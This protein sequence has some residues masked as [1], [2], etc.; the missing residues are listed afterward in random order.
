MAVQRNNEWEY[1]EETQHKYC[2]TAWVI[3]FQL[4]R[5]GLHIPSSPRLLQV[6]CTALCQ[7]AGIELSSEK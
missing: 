7:S 3:L 4:S 2:L 5:F 1:R 6:V